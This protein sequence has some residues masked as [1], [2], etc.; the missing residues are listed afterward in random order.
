MSWSRR[1]GEPI[2][3][4]PPDCKATFAQ[5]A[6]GEIPNADTARTTKRAKQS[7]ERDTRLYPLPARKSGGPRIADPDTI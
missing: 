5:Q 4:Q 2:V 6:D 3:R 1:H 7:G